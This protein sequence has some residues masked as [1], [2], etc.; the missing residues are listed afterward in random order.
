MS[1]LVDCATHARRA[2]RNQRTTLA[3]RA[4]RIT[5]HGR[6]NDVNG[7]TAR[8]HAHM[9]V[10][11]ASSTHQRGGGRARFVVARSSNKR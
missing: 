7:T 4:W 8:A 9:R 11:A 10:S 5:V 1:T 3:A 2:L 6:C